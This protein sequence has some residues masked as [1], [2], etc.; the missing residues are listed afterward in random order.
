MPLYG[1]QHLGPP[2]NGHPLV[3][4]GWSFQL[5]ASIAP[6]ML[7]WHPW[8]F[9]SATKQHLYFLDFPGKLWRICVRIAGHSEYVH[10]HVRW[11]E[12]M[13]APK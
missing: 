12:V 4:L 9:G 11:E 7:P 13:V 2:L 8:R 5:P 6:L 1:L 3:V 10:L